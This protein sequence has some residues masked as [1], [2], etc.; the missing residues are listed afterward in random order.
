MRNATKLTLADR[1]KYFLAQISSGNIPDFLRRLV[2]V[3][4]DGKDSS[5][6][7]HKLIIWVSPDYLAIGCDEDYVRTPLTLQAALEVCRLLRCSLPT[8]RI[9]DEIF[10]Q[11]YVKVE[12]IPLG[13]PRQAVETFLRHNGLIQQQLLNTERSALIAGAKKDIVITRALACKPDRVAIYG[14][15]IPTGEPIQPL[16]TVHH[17]N[18]VDYSHGLRLVYR[19]VLLDGKTR[20]IFELLKS[21]E[22]SKLLSNEGA[23]PESVLLLAQPQSQ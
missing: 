12:P 21:P 6:V 11:A 1:E 13:E 4:L 18:Y 7:E 16:S 10:K 15:H 2:P 9:V 14:W 22:L 3:R 5:C 19:T 17:A 20:D 23:I 8:T